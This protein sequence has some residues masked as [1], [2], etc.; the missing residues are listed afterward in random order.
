[1]LTLGLGIGLATVVFTVVNGVLLR[2]LAYPDADRLVTLWQLDTGKGEREKPPPGNFLDWRDRNR[3]FEH[4]AAAI[5]YGYDL[6]GE[7]DPVGL[8][9][10]QIT[11][12]FLEALSVRPI[13]GRTFAAEE[14]QPGGPRTAP[15]DPLTFVLAA[16]V[17]AVVATLAA[18]IPARRATGVSPL[19]ALRAE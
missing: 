5:P 19:A 8:S 12:G 2:P 1:V 15:T 3:S 13:V 11:R 7:G 14:Y 18:W 4:L 17:L 6:L 16:L 9:A 10:F